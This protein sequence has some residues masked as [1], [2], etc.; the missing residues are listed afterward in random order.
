MRENRGLG[1]ARP[2]IVEVDGP[3]VETAQRRRTHLRSRRNVLHD[4]VAKAPHVMQQKVRVWLEGLVRYR[5]DRAVPGHQRRGVTVCAPDL[6]ED[7]VALSGLRRLW[8]ARGWPEQRHEV[9]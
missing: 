4:T 1:C 2:A 5:R 8:T 6:D 7:V 9:R 3:R